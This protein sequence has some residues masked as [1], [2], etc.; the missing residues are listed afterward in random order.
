MEVKFHIQVL[1][2]VVVI[3]GI[4]TRAWKILGAKLG[5]LK[6]WLGELFA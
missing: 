6:F 4:Q 2:D 5:D 1:Y 3:E